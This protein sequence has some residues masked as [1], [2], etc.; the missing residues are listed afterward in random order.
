MVPYSENRVPIP[1][2]RELQERLAWFIRLRWLAAAGML[3]GAV[4]AGLMA[5]PG[6]QPTPVFFIGLGVFCYNILFRR[7][8]SRSKREGRPFGRNITYLQ[9]ALDW[10][11]LIWV[12]HF[13]GGIHSPLTLAFV[14]HII[15]G[16]ILLSRRACYYMAAIA[17]SLTGAVAAVEGLGAR[18]SAWLDLPVMI[19][20]GGFSS[21]LG[22]WIVNA[23]FF[24]VVAYLATSITRRLREKEEI[25]VHSEQALDHLY[26][27][28]EALYGIGKIINSTLDMNEVLSL[29]A[30]NAAR[31]MGMKACSIRIYDPTGDRLS[32]G[33]SYGLSPSF[34]DKGS[35]KLSETPLDRQ[36][37]EQGMIQVLEVKDDDRF[38]YRE[39]A[40][41]EGI[42]SAL[43]APITAK[44]RALGVIR[45]YSAE[46]HRFSKPEET[47][48]ANLANLGA[49]AIENAHAY[50]ELKTMNEQRMWLA[51]ITH[52]Q[53]RAPLAAIQSVLDA[54]RYAGPLT[55]KQVELLER[56]SR[57]IH[58]VFD[59][60]RDLLDLAA[61]QH[62][63]ASTSATSVEV[64]QALGKV[65]EAA[66][67]RAQA[68]GLEFSSAIPSGDL[69]VQAQAGD[70]E[71]I[72]SN[73][74]DNAVK[75]TPRG[76]LM[77]FEC[78]LEDDAVRITVADSGMGIE[79]RDQQR[80]FEGF[81]RT[82]AAKDSGEMGTGLGLSIV[83]S[84]V[85]RNGGTLA[86]ESAPG[87]GTSLTITLPRFIAQPP[88]PL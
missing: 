63:P 62:A 42:H 54:V 4:A 43:C 24:G 36:T 67:E 41:Q 26:R 65:I 83:R 85:E 21:P 16:A 50:A 10:C 12:V 64:H 51:R 37:L 48:L 3:C 29:I 19:P 61:A 45:V 5:L 77:R 8:L 31:L 72:V 69:Q 86:L 46:P 47:L 74:L 56:G 13:T 40:A 66:R 17:A 49:L 88:R 20:I 82:Q 7:Q 79:P 1:L 32:T 2:E 6:F 76:G 33:G 53:L 57:R 80:V 35:V 9:I 18:Q 70:L 68:K 34:A 87:K 27:E 75:Y 30:E 78:I 14:F 52:H 23:F 15:I 38:A 71:R 25:L 84:L 28:T 59:L 11:A 60:I 58:D 22:V 73:L 44:N 81:Y 39:E 55:E